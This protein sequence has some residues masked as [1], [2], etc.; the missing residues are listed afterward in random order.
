LTRNGLFAVCLLIGSRRQEFEWLGLFE[1]IGYFAGEN[2]T[3]LYGQF[4]D[5]GAG[6]EIEF[7]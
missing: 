1:L 5:W 4:L 6:F 2:L 7:G 3:V